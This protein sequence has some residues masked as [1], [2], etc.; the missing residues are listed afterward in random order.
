MLYAMR[1]LLASTL[2]ACAVH[3]QTIRL[4]APA[5]TPRYGIAEFVLLINSPRFENPFTAVAPV[6]EITLPAGGK[7]T[8]TGFCDSE[9]GSVF[10]VRYSPAQT[11]VH[12]YLLRMGSFR[13]KGEFTAAAS[14]SD[15]P[16][17][18]DPEHPRHFRFAS[19]K[20][21]YHLG[22]TAYHLLDPSKSEAEINAVIDYCHRNGFNKIRFL[23]SGYPRDT[24]ARTSTDNEHGVP[25]PKRAPNYG[26]PAGRVNALP[27]WPGKPHGYDFTR[28]HLPHWRRAEN[29]ILEMG[30]KGIQ[31]TVILTIEKQNLPDEYG[32]L[33]DHELR[34]YRYAFTRLAAYANVWWDLG[35][36]H[37]EYRDKA[38][39]D[40][41]GALLR[42]LDPHHRLASVHAYADFWYAHS[43]WATFLVTQQYGNERAVYDWARKYESIPK[44]YVNEEYGYEGTADAPGHLQNTGWTRR[45]HWAIAMAGGY[46]TYGDWSNGKAYFYS[47]DAGPGAAALQLKH[48][49]SLFESLP[50][51]ALVPCD[52]QPENAFCLREPSGLRIYYLPNG[53][54]LAF[55]KQ[56]RQIS[57]YDPRTGAYQQLTSPAVPAG[58]DWVLLV[59]P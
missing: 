3:A 12:R 55:D 23:L 25:D 56:P 31:A 24:A 39:G 11:G 30:R 1:K 17:E 14:K 59:K 50:F 49:R 43:D 38:W 7:Q 48:L 45:T 47:G 36:E 53:G 46:A 22:Y 4:E 58:E 41:M 2:L 42:A 13:Q 44:P 54:V 19:A 35:N 8:V 52:P 6:V 21:F 34:F 33:S 29:A 37:N 27:A 9:D 26:A 28:F 40:A 5:S 20:P 57:R 51:A 15:G 16:V 32:R 18:I 10:R